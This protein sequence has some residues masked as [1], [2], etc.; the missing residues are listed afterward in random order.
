[1]TAIEK[2]ISIAKNEVGYLEKKE[3]QQPRQQDG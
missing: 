3:Q 1:M 2:L